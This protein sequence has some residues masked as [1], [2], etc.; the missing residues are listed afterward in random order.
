MGFLN[1][2]RSGE[3]GRR[4]RPVLCRTLGC[5]SKALLGDGGWQEREVTSNDASGGPS[6]LPQA[7]AILQTKE[8]TGVGRRRLTYLATYQRGQMN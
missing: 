1:K 4:A 2:G 3:E 6:D 7:E 8:G 5:L